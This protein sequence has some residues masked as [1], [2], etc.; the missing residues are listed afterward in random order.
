M[1]RRERRKNLKMLQEGLDRTIASR[2]CGECTACCTA[3]EVSELKKPVGKPCHLLCETGCGVY[4]ERPPSCKAYIC[5]W[6]MGFG[7]QDQRPDKIG[8]VM[9]PQPGTS[10]IHPGF[11][12]HEC[13]DGAWERFDVQQLVRYVAQMFVLVLIRNGLPSKVLCPETRAAAVR[14]VIDDVKKEAA[15]APLAGCGDDPS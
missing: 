12:V 10:P 7:L 1:N 8:I 2:P 4:P 14:A 13:I 3:L 6:K 5:G 15:K 9:S 11:V